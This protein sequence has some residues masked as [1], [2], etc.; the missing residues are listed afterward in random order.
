MSAP[1]A[2]LTRGPSGILSSGRP[3]SRL[4][5][6]PFIGCASGHYCGPLCDVFPCANADP[7]G[8]GEIEAAAA[9]RE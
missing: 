9:A 7:T 2:L 3:L 8:P 4:D 5:A 6:E 1:V